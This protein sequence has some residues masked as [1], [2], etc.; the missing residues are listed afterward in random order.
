MF[1]WL[2]HAIARRPKLFVVG[3]V[4]LLVLGGSATVWGFGE[5][6][7]F[8][9]MHSSESM[10]P[11]SE[12]DTVLEKTS[13]ESS[14]D[15]A[16]IVVSGVTS[17]AVEEEVGALRER[18]EAIPA[19]SEVVDPLAIDAEVAAAAEQAIS[20]A[21]EQAL[22][23]NQ[24]ELSQMPEQMRAGAIEQIE[25]QAREAAQAELAGAD[26]PADAFRSGNGF[27]IAVNVSGEDTGAT[28][29]ILAAADDFEADIQQIS[30][31][32]Q[33]N[34]SSTTVFRDLILDLVKTDLI[35]GE[36]IGLPIALFL[37]VI[38]FGGLLAA[39]LPLIGAL[40]SIAIGTGLL[41]ALTF[42]T[43]V[44][45]FILNII[46]IIGLALSIDYGLLIVS[47]YREEVANEL[48][49]RKLP[50]DGT[51]LPSDVGTLV[52]DAVATTVATAGRTVSFS[53]LTIAFSIAGLLIMEAPMLK[54][55]GLG[56]VIV[57]VLAVATAVTLVPAL[58][59]LAG[60]RL[61]VPSWLS[62]RKGFGKLVEKVGD[63]ASDEGVFSKLAKW[64][65]ARP[66]PILIVVGAVLLLMAVPIRD[67]NMRQNF[68]EYVPADSDAAAAYEQMQDYPAFATP[69][70]TIVA[71]VE[72]EQTADLVSYVGG[73]EGVEWVSQPEAINDGE[74]KIDFYVTAEDQVG[75]EV[76][77]VVHTIRDHDPGYPMYVGGAAALQSDFNQSVIDGAPAAA[78]IVVLAVLILLFL[79][80]GSIMAPLKALLINM[81]SLVAG[82]G[83][84]VFVFENGLFGLPQTNGLETFVV[85]A[86][87]AFGF[88]L[89]MDY[90]VFLLA[91][92]KEYW[93]AGEDNDTAVEK[94]LQRSGRIITS[95]AAIIIAVFIGFVFGDMLAI[96]Q[97]GVALAL[98]VAIDATLVRMLLVPSTMTLLGKWNWWAPKPLKRIYEKFKIIH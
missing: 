29:H 61:V 13:T 98:I 45:T 12:S 65:H 53:A 62:R 67:L 44:D 86:A 20:T 25:A 59:K 76:T 43:N 36:A 49:K 52:D 38:V 93:D 26:N 92:I 4:I 15:S 81:F 23:A 60:H 79:M 30:P 37:L 9:R 1:D 5:G 68:V 7:L 83:A 11:G 19:V 56:G 33:A 51:K 48:D 28:E 42:V 70:G 85:A 64:V 39:G 50:T 84:T 35:R 75:D 58:I 91:R 22:E 80:T 90:E 74:T 27:V 24:A 41:W 95:A 77:D 73:L 87:V 2:G 6:N 18:L 46:S 97:V 78:V 55:I 16:V 69:S 82:M 31:D 88:G 40:T 8:T 32:A 21:V 17:D 94:G 66:I 89:A 96:K 63:S 3:W 54:M 14:P 34:V 72:P 57:T 71:E 47:R 10:V